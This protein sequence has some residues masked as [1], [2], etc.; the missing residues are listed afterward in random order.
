MNGLLQSFIFTTVI[1]IILGIVGVLF[2]SNFL[3]WFLLGF[4][5][6]YLSYYIFNTVL[7]T[8]AKI[9]YNKNVAELMKASKKN[10]VKLKCAVC[11]EINDVD[12]NLNEENSFRCTKCNTLNKVFVNINTVQLT[13]ILDT[14]KGIITADMVETIENDNRSRESK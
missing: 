11:G 6:Q 7:A 14:S 13:E 3:I 9:N 5:F 8:F 12:I 10:V 4:I 2:G 1:S